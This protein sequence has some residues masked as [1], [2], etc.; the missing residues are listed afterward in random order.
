VVSSHA[1]MP[2]AELMSGAKTQAIQDCFF[3]MT[4][5]AIGMM[6]ESTKMPRHVTRKLTF[7][8]RV[9]KQVRSFDFKVLTLKPA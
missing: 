9:S 3:H 8:P 4:V 7:Y 5:Q 1:M 6:A 2:A